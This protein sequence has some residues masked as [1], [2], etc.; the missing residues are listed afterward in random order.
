VLIGQ[1]DF[2]LCCYPRLSTA[3]MDALDC[4]SLRADSHQV[5]RRWV[6]ALN[7]LRCWREE[8]RNH[9]SLWSFL[10]RWLSSW[11]SST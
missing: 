4:P 10:A 7:D 9:R 11:T 6:F 5:G 8:S 3:Y 1:L 2:S